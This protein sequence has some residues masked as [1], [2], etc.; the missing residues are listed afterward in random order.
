MLFFIAKTSKTN[1][2]VVGC[3][4]EHV[5]IIRPGDD[6]SGDSSREHYVDKPVGLSEVYHVGLSIQGISQHG[7]SPCSRTS[8]EFLSSPVVLCGAPSVAGSMRPYKRTCFTFVSWLDSHWQQMRGSSDMNSQLCQ[9]V[10]NCRCRH[11]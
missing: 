9:E 11:D 7:H 3:G 4:S 2:G 6:R 5:K 1:Q 8:F 10:C